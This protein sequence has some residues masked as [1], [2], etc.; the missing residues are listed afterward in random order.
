MIWHGEFVPD[1]FLLLALAL[2]LDALVGDMAWFFRAIPHPVAMLGRAIGFFEQKLNRTW[3]S[4]R[5]R[6]IR[7][8]V[9]VTV[10]CAS[11]LAAGWAISVFVAAYNF[12][13]VELFVVTVLV[14]QRGLY[15]HVRAVAKA[16]DRDGLD[17]GRAAVAHIVGRDPEKLD[18]GGV[19][20]AA[21]ESLAENFADGVIA[22]VFWYLLFGLPGLFFCKAVN[23]LDSMLGYRNERYLMFGRAAARLDDAVMWLPARLSV[24]FLIAG[25]CVTPTGNPFRALAT[26]KSDAGKHPSVN[27]GWPEAAMAGAL[28]IWLAGPRRYGNRVRQARK[29]HETG[30]EAQAAAILRSLRILIA[31]QILFAMLL[32]ALASL[33]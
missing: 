32:L 5:N 21:V 27:A 17:A 18:A 25:A 2:L 31:S 26:I 30:A 3:R 6:L 11:A 7:G 19:A 14:A 16:L 8:A 20:R 33:A 23:T 24:V 22:P 13:F 9:V 4:D 29:F 12:W 10:V 1:R 28:D 15:S